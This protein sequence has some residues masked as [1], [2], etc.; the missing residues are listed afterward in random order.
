MK[1]I[2]LFLIFTTIFFKLVY[3]D[4][5][6]LTC[7]IS[8][9]I[10]DTGFFQAGET[11][12]IDTDTK[13]EMIIHMYPSGSI[14]LDTNFEAVMNHLYAYQHNNL[15]SRLA[16]LQEDL[17]SPINNRKWHFKYIV[18]RINQTIGFEAI[19]SNN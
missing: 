5:L 10:T 13:S 11:I 9:E 6:S 14:K 16:F 1:I 19:C 7:I 2:L 8:E 18:I 12:T 3:A 4:T 17:F 15:T